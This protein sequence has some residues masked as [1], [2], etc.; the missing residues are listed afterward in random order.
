MAKDDRLISQ[1]WEILCEY[2][3]IKERSVAADHLVGY[4][5]DAGVAESTLRALS[6][7]D[8]YME[9]AVEEYLEDDI[10]DID[11]E[12]VWDSEDED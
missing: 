11:D 3:P 7:T 9:S 4:L 2:I 12:E 5:V 1:T 10:V 8:Q 6:A